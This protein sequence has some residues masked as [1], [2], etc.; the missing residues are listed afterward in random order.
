VDTLMVRLN[1][2]VVDAETF[3][4]NLGEFSEAM[5]SETGSLGKLAFNDSLHAQLIQ[6]MKDLDELVIYLKEEGINVSLF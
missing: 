3:S 1:R 4:R 2:V 5:N 6:T